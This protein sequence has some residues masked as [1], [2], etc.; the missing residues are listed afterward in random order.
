[1]KISW[2]PQAGLEYFG[3][4]GACRSAC[5]IASWSYPNGPL[6]LPPTTDWIL[7]HVAKL[8]HPS[9]SQ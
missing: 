7:R 3:K 8:S 4:L 6:R 5:N 2:D 9:C 1:M